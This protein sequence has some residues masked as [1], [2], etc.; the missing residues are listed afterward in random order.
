MASERNITSLESRRSR[1]GPAAPTEKSP[2]THN[3]RRDVQGL[4]ALAVVAVI[5]N[6][7][8]GW[9][10]GGFVGV[11]VFFVLSGYLITGLLLREHDRT[12]TISFVG[13]YKRR[14]KRILPAAILV[15]VVTVTV[16]YF[17]TP[18][19]RFVRTATDSFWALLFSSNW[20][21]ALQGTD[22]FQQDLQPS[23]VQ[24]YWS[25]A[26]EEQFY[27]VWPWVMLGVL[28]VG[29]KIFAWSSG[30]RRVAVGTTIGVLSVASFVYA[31]YLSKADTNLAYFSSFDRAWE[32]GVGALVAVFGVYFTSKSVTLRT[33][34]SWVGFALIVAACFVVDPAQGFPAPAAALPTL[35]TA[36]VLLA[37]EQGNQPY[38]WPLTNRAS[39]Y[40]GDISYSLYLW[41]FP[42]LILLLAVMPGDNIFYYIVASA[43]L[44]AVSVLSYHL[45]E[46]PIRKSTWLT[47]VKLSTRELRRR[48]K[49]R[50]NFWRRT[51]PRI[52]LFGVMG[53]VAIA[54]VYVAF[55]RTNDL[56]NT[57]AAEVGLNASQG[58]VAD[59][60]VGDVDDATRCRGAAAMDPA[61]DCSDVD[62]GSTLTPTAADAPDDQMKVDGKSLCWIQTTGDLKPCPYGIRNADSV[63]VA[64][65]GDSHAQHLLP[66]VF[67][68]VT[69]GNWAVDAFTGDGCLLS[70]KLTD[71]CGEMM[72]KILDRVS[73]GEYDIVIAHSARTKGNFPEGFAE[74]FQ[75]VLDSGTKLVVVPDVPA[76]S[77]EAM[78]CYQRVG[79]DP[80]QNDC[81]TPLD[82]QLP[83]PLLT[84][85]ASVEGVN[86]VDLTQ[87]FCRD[88]FCPSVVGNVPV[89]RDGGAHLTQTYAKS[90]APYLAE[91]IDR[92]VP[93]PVG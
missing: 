12:K 64:V 80:K 51:T 72:P 35:A 84:A 79:F 26:V 49:R 93:A 58:V 47:P 3:I 13:F 1:S 16:A 81:G 39:R 67:G 44:V 91:G 42:V 14:V 8:L 31:L 65:V 83:D 82:G 69:Q 53:A 55:V 18:G 77:D 22:Y 28:A 5:L 23:P 24:H 74:A 6:H 40:V 87:Y 73:S 88:G 43:I 4:R 38:L 75:R 36:L 63:R 10:A 86:L 76:V 2:A 68:G 25:L 52:A 7:M 50:R 30:R 78:L 71:K 54:L 29:I 9:P 66:A 48:K 15:L 45:V 59:E 70:T 32:L 85:A 19:S 27:F 34:M 89:Y 17:L 56:P 20:N 62:L 90:L 37:G 61:S 33:V 41:H 11:D 57:A 46:D 92:S 21:L 60:G